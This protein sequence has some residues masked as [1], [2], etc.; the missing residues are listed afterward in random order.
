MLTVSFSR[1]SRDDI[2]EAEITVVLPNSLQ[3][4]QVV[5]S[6]HSTPCQK[7]KSTENHCIFQNSHTTF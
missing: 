6:K 5:G 4:G 1:T 7:T 2:C 3:F